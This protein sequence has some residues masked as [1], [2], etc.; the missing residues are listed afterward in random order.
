MKSIRNVLGMLGWGVIIH[1]LMGAAPQKPTTKPA[2]TN[3]KT[4]AKKGALK[5]KDTKK[6][7][8]A[9]K[10][11][12]PE[13][14]IVLAKYP[15]DS[16]PPIQMKDGGK[17]AILTLHDT[18]NPATGDYVKAGIGWAKEW[19]ANLIVLELDTP[20][21]LLQ[22]TRSIVKDILNSPI[23]V[24]VFVTPSGARAGSAGVFIT[25]AGHIAA[26][27]PGTN[28]GAAHPVMGGKDPEKAGGK[29]MARK[30]EN[31]TVAFI[32]AIAKQRRRNIAWGKKAVIES[33]S[34]TSDEALR[35][36]VIDVVAG[37]TADLLKKIDGKK[38]YVNSFPM[39][40]ATKN[41]TVKRMSM[42]FKQKFLNF[43]ANPQIA[44]FLMMIGFAGIMM[45]IYHPGAIFPGVLGG[46]CLFLA[47]VGL[48]VLPINYGGVA[49]IFLGGLL[50]VGELITP[51]FGIL[52]VGGIISMFVG[53]I[54]LIDSPDPSMQVPMPMII[55]TVSTLTVVFG[56]ALWAVMRAYNKPPLTGEHR[57]IGEI[58][59]VRAALNPVGTVRVFGEQWNAES[60]DGESI[61]EGTE[62]KV[63]EVK[64]LK[65]KVVPVSKS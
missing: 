51:A 37:D 19:G 63:V 20:G 10:A 1:F 30:V 64:G 11:K 58:G 59:T 53:S 18:I 17:V 41:M 49:L 42:S 27:S 32:E 24:V 21:G 33:A 57:M 13:P 4:V 12:K 16:R 23:P 5:G 50:L 34:I 25:M 15:K 3:K 38:I 9:K 29:H 40:L 26:M 52:F 60:A 28:I 7:K 14:E 43:F 35:L 55:A 61:A 46:I 31:D 36:K 2:L 65:V 8:K 6:G 44:Y 48:Q 39:I 45:E 62:I 54:F 22:T 47:F 56:L